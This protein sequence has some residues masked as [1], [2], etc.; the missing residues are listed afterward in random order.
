MYVFLRY[1]RVRYYAFI[2]L[3]LEKFHLER[4]NELA[5]CAVHSGGG[6]NVDWQLARFVYW[7]ILGHTE[8]LIV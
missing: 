4:G 2:D 1:A 5:S 6:G 7:P 3:A 8:N